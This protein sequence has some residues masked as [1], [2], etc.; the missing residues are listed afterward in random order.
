VKDSPLR[1]WEEK[2]EKGLDVSGETSLNEKGLLP[3]PDRGDHRG[4]W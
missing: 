4:F 1:T 3:N 2:E